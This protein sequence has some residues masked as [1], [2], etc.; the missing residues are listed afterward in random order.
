MYTDRARAVVAAANE[1]AINT[2]KGGAASLLTQPWCVSHEIRPVH[3][4]LGIVQG[5]LGIARHALS[6]CGASSEALASTLRTICPIV[7][8]KNRRPRTRLA[9]SR[10]TRM[11]VGTDA[12]GAAEQAGH[13]W[14]GTEHLL[15]AILG[16]GPSNVV[17]C[18]NK[19]NA[20]HDNVLEAVIRNNAGQAPMQPGADAP[21]GRA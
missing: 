5:P 16:R 2:A 19:H 1:W 3:L 10:H 11:L 4:A 9:L 20:R 18:F 8:L 17:R 7:I 13:A 12:P 21:P 15:L 14:V 6:Q